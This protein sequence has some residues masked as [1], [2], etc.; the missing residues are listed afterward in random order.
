MPRR[1]EALQGINGNDLNT[2]FSG[3]GADSNSLAL[4]RFKD[5]LLASRSF[6]TS[7]SATRQTALPISVEIKSMADSSNL[8][9]LYMRALVATRHMFGQNVPQKQTRQHDGTLGSGY[10]RW[11][12]ISV[13]AN[14][15]ALFVYRA[16]DHWCRPETSGAK[17]SGK[18]GF[19]LP[20][21]VCGTKENADLR[22]LFGPE[23]RW[24][25]KEVVDLEVI[26]RNIF[27]ADVLPVIL[28]AEARPPPLPLHPAACGPGGTYAQRKGQGPPYSCSQTSTLDQ[29]PTCQCNRHPQAGLGKAFTTE[30]HP[31]GSIRTHLNS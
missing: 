15:Y 21:A 29:T 3:L 10:D 27:D 30:P 28:I 5:D 13:E 31:L 11:P 6:P 16:L 22:H 23:G 19:V 1:S 2:F 12:G 9:A 25:I 26:W 4:A 17:G 24:T 20:L 8:T 7:L 18:L 14:L